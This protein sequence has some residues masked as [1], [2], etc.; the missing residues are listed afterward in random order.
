L[1]P[2]CPCFLFTNNGLYLSPQQRIS[3]IWVS[4]CM[5]SSACGFLLPTFYLTCYFIHD[6]LLINEIYVYDSYIKYQ[7]WPRRY[8]WWTHHRGQRLGSRGSA[9]RPPSRTRT[10]TTTT[11]TTTAAAAHS[12]P[13]AL[14][15]W[16]LL[17]RASA[18]GKR[19][20]AHAKGKGLFYFI[21]I[22][23][24]YIILYLYV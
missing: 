18:G 24:I 14:W 10:P 21:I 2:S 19:H 11:T 7:I 1:K 16:L 3:L 22:I 5:T 15:W 23:L 9:R 6:N 17:L 4:V 8:H 12:W 20:G 13:A